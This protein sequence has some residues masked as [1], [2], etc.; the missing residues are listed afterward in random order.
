M[1]VFTC[2]TVCNHLPDKFLHLSTKWQFHVHCPSKIL[3]HLFHSFLVCLG[4][5]NTCI[6]WWLHMRCW[7]GCQAWY[8]WVLHWDPLGWKWVSGP[9]TQI[10]GWSTW[11]RHVGR[12]KWYM[13][14]CFAWS[15]C[16][17]ASEAPP[18]PWSQQTSW[19]HISDVHISARFVTVIVQSLTCTTITVRWPSPTHLKKTTWSMSQWENPSFPTRFSMSFWYQHQP[20]CFSPYRVLTRWQ[21]WF[22]CAEG[23]NSHTGR[24]GRVDT[25]AAYALGRA[26]D[27]AH[28]GV[29]L[30][31]D[32]TWATTKGG[33]VAALVQPPNRYQ[34]VSNFGWEEHLS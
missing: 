20:L 34:H 6:P 31:P 8:T 32:S 30:I 14:L 3:V 16:L 26:G 28:D 10:S 17:T 25:D 22:V 29:I 21:M 12:V 7:V 4:Y 23:L 24:L 9:Q 15:Q 2:A 5:L 11:Y 19:Y 18:G 33:G 13:P 1:L 27:L